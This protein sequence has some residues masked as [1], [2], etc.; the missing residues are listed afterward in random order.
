V[1]VIAVASFL[2][3]CVVLVATAAILERRYAHRQARLGRLICKYNDVEIAHQVFRGEA[4]E[5]QSEDQLLDSLGTPAAIDCVQ[6]EAPSREVWKYRRRRWNRLDLWILLEDGL[7]VDWDSREKS[8]FEGPESAVNG[9]ASGPMRI[10]SLKM[11]PTQAEES[12]RPTRLLQET[13]AVPS[14]ISQ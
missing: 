11:H 7:V 3:A 9:E 6:L 1:N 2:S 10:A 8:P 5:G 12:E 4:W 14:A 13:G